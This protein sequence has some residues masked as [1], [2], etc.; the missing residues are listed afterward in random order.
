MVKLKDIL[1]ESK[2]GYLVEAE[3]TAAEKKKKAEQE[4]IMATKIDFT[5]KK[6]K[7]KGKKDTITVRGA[8][9][10]GE[11]HPAYTKAK[12]LTKKVDKKQKSADKK[13]SKKVEKDIEKIKDIK[14]TIQS[15]K[16]DKEVSVKDVLPNF[17]TDKKDKDTPATKKAQKEIHK[18]F[19]K[20]YEKEGD[21]EF[22]KRMKD[23]DKNGEPKLSENEMEDFNKE[24]ER[25]KKQNEKNKGE[26][27]YDEKPIPTKESWLR[28]TIT[29]KQES[30]SDYYDPDS[31]T[32]DSYWDRETG[33]DGDD[34]DWLSD[35]G[36]DDD[37]WDD[38]GGKKETDD[39][40]NKLSKRGDKTQQRA[41]EFK[42]RLGAG[43]LKK[44]KQ[45]GHHY[46]IGEDGKAIPLSV[47][48]D[49]KTNK[50]YAV[51]DEGNIYENDTDDF[52]D[53]KEPTTNARGFEGAV[54]KA[55]QKK[56]DIRKGK[57][58]DSDEYDKTSFA[59]LLGMLGIETDIDWADPFGSM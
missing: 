17:G 53:M 34:D 29:K 8:L 12:R 54:T 4:K 26:D 6:G 10:Q 1:K 45:E 7:N 38:W 42:L 30:K 43:T 48:K 18:Y 23:T 14:F 22:K 21:I 46:T 55:G 36:D 5:I 49:P 2:V 31:H 33:D 25:V 20:K 15:P 19:V 50:Y 58:E 3:P 51:D 52:R 35:F 57:G 16:G 39:Y 11:D 41:V 24:V 44:Q 37:D 27:W 59:D 28:E 47:F 56:I 32:G 40:G 9:N 13:V